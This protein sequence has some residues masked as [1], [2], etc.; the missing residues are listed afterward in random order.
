[1]PSV[2]EIARHIGVSKSTVSLVLNNKPGVSDSK[3]RQVLNALAELEAQ[4]ADPVLSLTGTGKETRFRSHKRKVTSLVVLHPVILHSNQVYS[5]FLQGIQD[6]ADRHNIQL[7]LAL[8]EPSAA[9]N[10]ISRLY[11]TDPNF[12]PDGMIIM[13]ARM[14]EPLADEARSNNIPYILLS[15]QAPD[16]HSSAVGWHE[17]E[18]AQLATNHLLALGH[19]SIAFIG[20]DEMYSYTHGRLAGYKTALEAFG[21]VPKPDWISLGD[22]ETATKRILQQAPYVTGALFIND[23]HAT[24][25]APVLQAAGLRIPKDLSI[26]SFDDTQEA[27]GFDPPLT[28]IKFPRYQIGLWAVNTLVNKINNPLIESMQINFKCLLVKRH[29]CAQVMSQG[30]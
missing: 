26:A 6:G 24:A 2:S 27:Q 10:H 23:T 30:G 4:N 9:H 15:R 28:S 8:N 12:R 1:M 20:G 7:R 14:H 17:A 13:G 16:I 3:R 29:S 19:R 5:E 18:A 11:L 25:G 21:I 22:G